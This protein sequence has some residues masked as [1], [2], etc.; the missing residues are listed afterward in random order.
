MRGT[1]ERFRKRDGRDMEEGGKRFCQ[2]RQWGLEEIEQQKN[3]SSRMREVFWHT[4]MRKEEREGVGEREARRGAE[5]NREQ[6]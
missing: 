3:F 5:G 2:R 1:G 4:Q 6:V